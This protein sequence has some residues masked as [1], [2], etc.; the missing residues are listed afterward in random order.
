MFP[1][2]QAAMTSRSSH[3]YDATRAGIMCV[4]VSILVQVRPSAGILPSTLRVY[5]NLYRRLRRS[6]ERFEGWRSQ[7]LQS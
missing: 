5:G 1:V 3:F 6:I 7:G 2:T 4:R